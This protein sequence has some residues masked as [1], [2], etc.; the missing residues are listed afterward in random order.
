MFD[1]VIVGGNL[2]GA[3]AAINAAK[4]DVKV[5]LIERNKKPY[6]PAHCGEAIPKSIAEYLKLDNIGCKY[7]NIKKVSVNISSLSYNY[8]LNPNWVYIFDRNF[9][10]N[11]L[12]K[13][14]KENGVKLFLG[15][16]VTDFIQ[17]NEVVLD[18]GN[19]IKGKII[20]DASGIACKIGRSI[21]LDTRLNSNDVGVCIQSR[22]ESNFVSDEAKIWFH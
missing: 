2:A 18:N 7:N 14:A 21:G 8:K 22:I 4:K 15:K 20:I 5:A 9:V 6:S 17:P 12:Q 10:E 3:T 13:K 1:V 16:K 19:K 11:Y